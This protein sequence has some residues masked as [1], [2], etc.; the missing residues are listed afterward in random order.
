MYKY[1]FKTP[2][3]GIRDYSF[4]DKKVKYYWERRQPVDPDSD[5]RYMTEEKYRAH[6]DDF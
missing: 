5:R 4:Y 3:S 1:L 6:Q 2:S